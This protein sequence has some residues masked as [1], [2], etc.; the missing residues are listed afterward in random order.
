MKS[1][2]MD[3]CALELSEDDIIKAMK[4][5]KGYLDITPGDFREIYQFA[6]KHAI[7]RFNQSITAKDVMT[8][9]VITVGTD[10]SLLGVAEILDNHFITGVPVIDEGRRVV[11]IISEKD[12][13]FHMGVEKE[14]T[15]MGVVT[16][17]LK[18]TGCIAVSMRKQKAWDIM[19][20]P[21]ITIG[22]NT[23]VSEIADIFTENKINRA[24]V[25]DN[26]H[27]LMGI[28]TRTDIVQSSC[29]IQI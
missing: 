18:G 13:I 19:T 26:G 3:S 11:G 5:M 28:V 21:A 22:E 8:R 23:P 25:T 7:E 10:T 2:H 6:Y 12:F 24:P 14:K 27:L 9:D 20:S 29:S 16:R 15:F 17:C 4:D 1:Q